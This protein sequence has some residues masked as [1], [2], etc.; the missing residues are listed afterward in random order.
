MKKLLVTLMLIGAAGGGYWWY[1]NQKK[2]AAPTQIYRTEEIKKGSVIQEVTATG[3][4]APIKEVEVGTQVNG[5]IERLYVDYNSLVTNGQ[6]I[7]EIDPAVYKAAY[8]KAQAQLRSN[9]ASVENIRVKLQLAEKTLAR[10]QQL[11]K[12][13]MIADSVLDDSVAEVGSLRAQLKIAEAT[14]EQS[15]ANADEAK[16]NLGYCTI[17]SPVDGVVISRDV[18]EG[19][20]VVSS[21]SA[22]KLFTIALDLK[23]IQVE[24]SVPEADVGMVRENQT[25]TF[26][27]DAY[28]DTFTGRVKQIRLASTTTSNVVTYPVIVEADNPDEKLFPG[29]TANISIRVAETNDVA[30]IPAAAF[31]FTP[32]GM[33][34]DIKGRKIWVLDE[35][36]KP[37]ALPVRV[38]I[39]D[40]THY[41]VR[42]NEEELLGKQVITGMG[43]PLTAQNSE[44]KNPFMPTPP[45]R[46]GPADPRPR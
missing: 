44:A 9:E 41:A 6:V 18:D 7:A 34:S 21:M 35:T 36:G 19:Q 30:V 37:K 2:T 4:V 25:V 32:Q 1:S 8:I 40:G 22:Q 20:T 10:N 12:E 17:A 14:V 27:V 24:A 45:R 39:T 43:M 26:T 29:M 33:T 11:S 16:T 13:K 23:R 15:R 38:G 31:R 3:T 42:E 46:R 28:R 5:P